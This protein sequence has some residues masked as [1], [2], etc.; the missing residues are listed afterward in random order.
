MSDALAL[1]GFIRQ[2]LRATDVVLA[3][4]PSSGNRYAFR[5]ACYPPTLEDY[6]VVA[7]ERLHG[8]RTFVVGPAKHMD[9]RRRAHNDWISAES[10][11]KLCD[12]S[13]ILSLPG[14]LP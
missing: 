6:C 11:I 14:R 3:W 7:P 9:P 5:M 1:Q 10:R 8:A 4:H 2:Q 13:E 12:E